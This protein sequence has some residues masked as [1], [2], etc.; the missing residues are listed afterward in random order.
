MSF[1]QSFILGIVQGLT[2]F[3]PISSSGH[4]V[5]VPALLGWEI[6]ADQAFVFDVLVQLG[7]LVAVF[8]YFW[9]D[10]R[11][12]GL[13][14]WQDVRRR[15]ISGTE[16][17]RMGWFIVLATLPA[18]FAGI[19]LKSQVEEA[20]DSVTATAYFLFLTAIFLFTAERFGRRSR[21]LNGITWADALWIGFFQV[22]AMFPGVSRSGSTIAGGMLRH[23]D[24]TS[25]ARFSFLMA[26]PIMIAAGLLSL[27]DLKD[28][29]NLDRFLPVLGVG[30]L[31]SAI[32]GYF[33]IRWLIA[34]LSRRSLVY[35]GVYVLL[36]GLAVLIGL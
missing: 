29:P 28:I 4:L 32:T 35:F 18:G 27:L 13:A 10:L 9:A 20:F 33:A 25:A 19:L 30:F 31:T 36:L 2:E 22:A 24:R 23:L 34:F 15:T 7:T 5:L 21:S 3:L 6:P 12:M 17:S 11:A 26:V 1:F 16:M 8:V 14:M